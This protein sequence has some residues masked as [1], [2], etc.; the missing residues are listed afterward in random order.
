MEFKLQSNLTHKV[1]LILN[2]ILFLILKSSSKERCSLFNSL[3]VHILF[4]IV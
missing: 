4:V 1:S 3:Q 2:Q